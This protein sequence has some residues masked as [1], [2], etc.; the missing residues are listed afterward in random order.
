MSDIDTRPYW[1]R[2]K[3]TV[4]GWQG[5][6]EAVKQW[7][8]RN[9]DKNNEHKRRHARKQVLKY[10]QRTDRNDEAWIERAIRWNE[11]QGVRGGAQGG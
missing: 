10:G 6:I 2:Q 7:K 8:L 4:E 5:H 11:A 1:Q 3:R 9:P